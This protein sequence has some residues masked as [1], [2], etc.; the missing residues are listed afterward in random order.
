MIGLRCEHQ[1]H[2]ADESP[3]LSTPMTSCT[4]PPLSLSPPVPWEIVSLRHGG[5]SSHLPVVTVTS[6]TNFAHLLSI[7]EHNGDYLS[8]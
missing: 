8:S 5:G 1:E 4:P 3:A 2:T 7:W 6:I